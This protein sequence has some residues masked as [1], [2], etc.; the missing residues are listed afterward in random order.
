MCVCA[1]KLMVCANQ[2]LGLHIYNGSLE[3]IGLIRKT[4]SVIEKCAL[5]CVSA[6][7]HRV[8]WCRLNVNSLSESPDVNSKQ[9]IACVP[10]S[11]ISVQLF[12]VRRL[13]KKL[14][15][16]MAKQ[17]SFFEDA[18]QYLLSLSAQIRS[19]TAPVDAKLIKRL[20]SELQRRKLK[21][22]SYSCVPCGSL[23]RAML[24]SKAVGSGCSSRSGRPRTFR[25]CWKRSIR[26]L[27]QSRHWSSS[28]S[29]S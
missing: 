7:S 28:I 25:S 16:R 20:S 22:V 8:A 23:I 1:N 5:P 17:K 9:T 2:V 4:L 6:L 10:A 15:K 19:T 3:D 24:S 26:T 14:K 27:K 29:G 18:E 12:A 21:R 11:S 13:V